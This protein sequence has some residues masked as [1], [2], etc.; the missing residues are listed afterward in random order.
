MTTKISCHHCSVTFP[1]ED[2]FREEDNKIKQ[3][4]SRL[5]N[6]SGSD[7][8]VPLTV[9]WMTHKQG[10]IIHHYISLY[11]LSHKFLC[12]MYFNGY[13]FTPERN[14]K[15]PLNLVIRCPWGQG[16][17]HLSWLPEFHHR[18]LYERR[19]REVCSCKLWVWLPLPQAVINTTLPNF[20]I[21][22]KKPGNL[23]KHKFL[24]F[25]SAEQDAHEEKK[26]LANICH[27]TIV[28][29]VPDHEKFLS[30]F[31]HRLV[32]QGAILFML[33]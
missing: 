4:S 14:I 5:V 30:S 31:P 29:K 18:S 28:F 7:S 26:W 17:Y 16:T 32:L 12:K 27:K 8:P 9:P 24:L 11:W 6:Q 1:L 13:C 22:K 20:V 21:K 10:G 33:S 2:S 19:K 25:G 15:L 3:F 23:W